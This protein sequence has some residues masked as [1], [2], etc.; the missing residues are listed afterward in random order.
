MSDVQPKNIPEDMDIGGNS[1]AQFLRQLQQ[2]AAA[3]GMTLTLPEELARDLGLRCVKKGGARQLRRMV[4]D[5]VE[6]PLAVFLLK[7]GKKPAKIKARLEDGQV[8]FL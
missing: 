4:Q 8:Q 1:L 5:Q 3:N 7:C 2:R 6:G